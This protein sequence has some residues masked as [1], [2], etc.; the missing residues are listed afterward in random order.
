MTL[1]SRLAKAEAV[2][3]AV[4]LRREADKVAEKIGE[5]AETLYQEARRLL[6]EDFYLAVRQADGRTD[7]KPVLHAIAADEGLEYRELSQAIRPIQRAERRRLARH[8]K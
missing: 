7:F 6:E 3:T 5:D 4:L 2:V 8:R 1:S